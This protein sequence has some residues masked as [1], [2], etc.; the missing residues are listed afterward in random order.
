MKLYVAS[1]WRNKN[2][3]DMVR[4]LKSA[5]HDVYDFRDHGFNWTDVPGHE[6][7]NLNSVLD[8]HKFLYS[9]EGKRGFERD[10]GA[11]K[12]ADAFVMV[13]PCGRSAHLEAGWALG[14]GK[15]T[16]VFHTEFNVEAELMYRM[17][18]L[19]T[20]DFTELAQWLQS[21]ETDV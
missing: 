5:G 13:M 2:Y 14:Q 18:N 8:H 10:L 17:A 9:L 20:H 16:A 1:S 7:W 21:L 11:M 4:L 6:D 3:P 19:I 12:W 15:P